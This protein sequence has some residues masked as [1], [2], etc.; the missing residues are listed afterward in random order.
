MTPLVVAEMVVEPGLRAVA[1]PLDSAEL[2][3]VAAVVLE[4]AQ[5]TCAVMSLWVLSLNTAVAVSCA[6]VPAARCALAGVISIDLMIGALFV[7]SM[8]APPLPPPPEQPASRPKN[9]HNRA[10]ASSRA[11]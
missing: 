4:D 9:P 10:H 7:E 1:I 2:P 6:F 11:E 8:A 3:M 5:A